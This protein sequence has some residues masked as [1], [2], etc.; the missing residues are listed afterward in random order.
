MIHLFSFD[1]KTSIFLAY[2]NRIATYP[3]D[4][5]IILLSSTASKTSCSTGS[6]Y[7][8]FHQQSINLYHKLHDKL[9]K[10]LRASMN[11]TA[12]KLVFCNQTFKYIKLTY[13][14][15]IIILFCAHNKT[16]LQYF[17]AKLCLNDQRSWFIFEFHTVRGCRDKSHAVYLQQGISFQC[18]RGRA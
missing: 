18:L 17:H 13:N 15:L 6:L 14:C 10:S 9:I 16:P 7:Y 3:M 11:K 1:V 12:P 2:S 5:L 8:I 4:S